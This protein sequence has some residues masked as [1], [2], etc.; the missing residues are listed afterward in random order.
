[1]FFS[2]IQNDQ[3]PSEHSFEVVE[4]KGVGHPDTL[5]DGLAEE[6]SIA[7][8]KYTKERFGVILHHHIDKLYIRGGE[9]NVGYGFS[10]MVEPINVILNGRFSETFGSERVPVKRILEQ[11]AL[12]RLEKILPHLKPETDVIF[13]HLYNNSS[14]NHHWYRPRDLSDLPDANRMWANDTALCVSYYPFTNA[15]MIALDAERF[16]YSGP[17][18]PR[19]EFVGQDIKVMV[20]RQIRSIHLTLCV[21]FISRYIHSKADYFEKKQFVVDELT[22]HLQTLIRDEFTFNLHINTSDDNP[23]RDHMYISGVG[24]CVDAGEEGVVGRG[25]NAC[26]LISS[27]RPFSMEAPFGKNPTYHSGRMLSVAARHLARSIADELVQSCTVA[28]ITQNGRSMIP[29]F[30]MNVRI[31]EYADEEYVKRLCFDLMSRIDITDS[32]LD[33]VLIPVAW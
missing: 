17:F 32:I 16:F 26:G 7:Y 13:T 22:A 4:R 15:E 6:L 1:M 33:G 3:N 29:P 14:H 21:P 23:C 28:L 20:V 25:N 8:A 30:A 9:W 12:S 19:Y 5:A 31:G 2:L 11:A 27:F 10:H 18:T 24:S